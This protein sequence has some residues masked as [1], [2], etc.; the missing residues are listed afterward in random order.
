VRVAFK[1]CGCVLSGG[2]VA[3]SVEES[4]FFFDFVFDSGLYF[5]GEGSALGRVYLVDIRVC[6]KESQR[7]SA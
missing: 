2:E 4:D 6:G 3:G 1:G 7:A 5:E